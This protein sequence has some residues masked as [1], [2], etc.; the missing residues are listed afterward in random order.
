M[1]FDPL[2][3]EAA[4]TNLQVQSYDGHPVLTWWQG[5]I[6]PQGFGQGEEMIY[7]SSY[8]QIGRV[9]AGNGYKADLHDF[10]IT[11]QGTALLSVFDPIDCNLSAV[12]GPS[13]GAVTD[14]VFQEI[15]LATGLVRR[16]WHSLDHVGAERV[17]QLARGRQ[18]D[19]AVRLLSHQLDRPARGR[20]DA[21]QRAQHVGAV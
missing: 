19:V 5:Y 3:G 10:H 17:I 8:Q 20:D 7:S 6:P 4:A 15:D 1:W 12:G 14:S 9:H 13:G 21:D 16:E 11:P 18:H 2:A